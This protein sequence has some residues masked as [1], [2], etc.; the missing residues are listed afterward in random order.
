[1]A[2]KSSRAI[3]YARIEVMSNITGLLFLPS[4]GVNVMNDV[5]VRI[6]RKTL[7]QDSVCSTIL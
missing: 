4:S 1:M 5:A 3:S 6:S 2:V 7:V